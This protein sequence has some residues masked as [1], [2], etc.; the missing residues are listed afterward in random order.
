MSTERTVTPKAEH[1]ALDMVLSGA[2]SVI[3][4]D[5][6]ENGELS[7]EQHTRACEFGYALLHAIRY[8]RSTLLT[9]AREHYWAEEAS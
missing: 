8:H 2:E 6:N 1:Y 5:P 4:D 9:T 3:E 7:D